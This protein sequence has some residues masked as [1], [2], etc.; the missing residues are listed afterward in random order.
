MTATCPDLFDQTLLTGSL[1]G[2]L[3]QADAS[4]VGRYALA[5]RFSD[6]HATGI[7]T[8]RSLRG[9]DPG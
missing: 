1:D 9:L 8:F 2:E 7:F 4:L 5:L 3:T 6:G